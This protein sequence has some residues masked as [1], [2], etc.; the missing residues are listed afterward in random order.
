MLYL[1]RSDNPRAKTTTASDIN[2]LI[3]A[4]KTHIYI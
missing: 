2:Q 3:E 1:E 4:N